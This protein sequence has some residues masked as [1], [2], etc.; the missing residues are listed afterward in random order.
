MKLLVA[1]IL[2]SMVLTGC[3]SNKPKHGLETVLLNPVISD[4]TLEATVM[5][6]GCTKP[7]HFYL[8]VSEEVVELRRTQPDLCRAA[9][10]MVRL[11]F[12]YPFENRVYRFKNKTR[13]TNRIS[14]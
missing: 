8:I 10:Q 3:A 14:R 12:S 4:Q 7:E 5:S 6:N 13:F 2:L 11:S 1:V 9:S